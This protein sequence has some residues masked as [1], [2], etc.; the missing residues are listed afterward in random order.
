M[1]VSVHEIT[2]WGSGPDGEGPNCPRRPLSYVKQRSVYCG[3]KKFHGL[4]MLTISYPNGMSTVIGI[5]SARNWDGNTLT[6]S[7]LD[8]VSCNSRLNNNLPLFSFH[9]DNG[10]LGQ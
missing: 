3:H 9:A 4:S 5:V 8:N 10:F 7:D 2:R 6:W 1:D